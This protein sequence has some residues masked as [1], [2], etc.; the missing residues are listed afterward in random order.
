MQSTFDRDSHLEDACANNNS[1]SVFS[2]YLGPRTRNRSYKQAQ[3]TSIQ[4]GIEYSDQPIN[5]ST[6]PVNIPAPSTAKM[7]QETKETGHINPETF[8]KASMDDKLTTLMV[9]LNQLHVKLDDHKDDL[10][11]EETG[12]IPRI[13]EVEETVDTLS[14]E[15]QSLKCDVTIIKGL[16]H[17]QDGQIQSLMSKICDLTA[18]QMSDNITITGL[19]SAK[20]DPAEETIEDCEKLVYDFI[21]TKMQLQVNEGE[22]LIA[23]RLNSNPESKFPPIMVVK[24]LPKLHDRILNNSK[25]LKDVLNDDEQS[26]FVNKQVPENISAERK[27]I[28]HAIKK[29]KVFNKNKTPQQKLKYKVQKRKLLI[30]DTPV[31]KDIHAPTVAEIFPEKIEQ[32]KMDKIKLVFA[33]PIQETGSVFTGVAAKVSNAAEIKRTYRKVKQ[34]YPGAT[35][36]PMGYDCQKK[37]SNQDDGEW[38]AGLCIQKVIERQNGINKAVFVVRNYGGKHLGSKRFELFEKAAKAALLKL[39]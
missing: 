9:S 5:Y 3:L 16:L 7:S 29:V 25:V 28:A 21:T 19:K 31:K 35:H 36:I 20:K 23:H 1:S 8:A 14:E 11:N 26:Y 2:S 4:E 17:K 10:H 34:L 38:A 22:I 27:E 37:Q 32:D 33:E 13:T 6:S 39:K 15:S 30:N 18:R 12:L 24:C